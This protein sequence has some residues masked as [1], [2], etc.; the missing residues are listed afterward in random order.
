VQEERESPPR[1][2]P[3]AMIGSLRLHITG[4]SSTLQAPQLQAGTAR[5]SATNARRPVAPHFMADMVAELLT[6]L[7][8][9]TTPSTAHASSPMCASV[10]ACCR[11]SPTV[12]SAAAPS[13]AGECRASDCAAACAAMSASP[14]MSRGTRAHDS[15]R[16][17]YAAPVFQLMLCQG[18]NAALPIRPICERRRDGY[19]MISS[20]GGHY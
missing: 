12:A 14:S 1:L 16:C 10:P 13:A 7:L 19:V 5:T 2:T 8:A 6:V 15:P 17:T 11:L 20:I 4:A 18:A 3:C 9:A